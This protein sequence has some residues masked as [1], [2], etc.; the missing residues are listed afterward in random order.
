MLETSVSELDF[1]VLSREFICITKNLI[2]LKFYGVMGCLHSVVVNMPSYKF[3]D[4]G[5]NPS[6]SGSV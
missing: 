5:S 4:P 2:N 1:W 3:V 6:L